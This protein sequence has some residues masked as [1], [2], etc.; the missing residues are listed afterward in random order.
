MPGPIEELARWLFGYIMN[1][2]RRH[3]IKAI[4][5]GAA[6]MV[7]P[8]W[9]TSC[10][11][12][13]QPPNIL[14]IAVDDLN[15]WT[16]CLGGRPG[17]HT[18]NL[19]RLANRGVLFTNAHCAA[20][21]CNPSRTSVFTGFSPSTSGIYYNRQHWR[22]S[23]VLEKA[24]TIPEYFRA[25]GYR[26]VGGGKLFHCLSWIKTTYG[27]DGNDPAVWD[28]YFPSKTAP[29][30]DF[31]WPEGTS[32]DE[33]ETVTWPPR[34][35][36]NTEGRPPYYFDWGPMDEPDKITSD[37]KV[38]DWAKSELKKTHNKPFFLAVGIFRPHI[39]WF[40]PKQY[41]DLYPLEEISLPPIQDNDLED[42]SPVGK[43]F[44]RR[45]WQEWILENDQWKQAVQAYLASISYVDAQLG[46]L[47]D[48]LDQSSYCGN[49]IIVLWS[50]HGMHI[51]EKEHWEKFTLWEESTRVP[52]IFVA[53]GATN[54]GIRCEQPVSL[55]DVYPTLI[56]LVGHEP[57]P[58]LEG[59]SLLPLLKNPHLKTGRAVVTT[60]GQ[61]NHGVRSLRWR[62]IRYHDGS[63]ELYS[64]QTDPDEY[65]NL[66]NREEYKELKKE[67]AS[68][69]PK[70][71]T[72]RSNEG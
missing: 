44:C 64:H 39:P 4:G 28:D 18:P 19:D 48:A 43:G 10:S 45:K 23:P 53:P 12:K 8:P 27:R 9:T 31:I 30:P 3:F 42:C 35:G 72:P 5:L 51:G 2:S 20:P 69:L 16:N 58:E 36:A 47:L 60:Y 34:A 50:D 66:A 46:R 70:I 1:K 49:T 71:N 40:V 55:L 68:W 59:Q 22:K 61:N 54:T 6:A 14:F 67:L 17:V 15:D 26:A 63:E 13:K 24:V 57:R 37:F 7:L 21:A 65:T 33:F 32:R 41:F 25:H 62:Y 56:D 29:M 52:L 11:E 38:I